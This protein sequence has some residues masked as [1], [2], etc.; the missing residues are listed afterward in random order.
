MLDTWS[1]QAVLAIAE[2]VVL[3]IFYLNKEIYMK[4][5]IQPAVNKKTKRSYMGVNVILTFDSPDSTGESQEFFD[6]L[7]PVNSRESDAI[8]FIDEKLFKWIVKKCEQLNR[9]P[10]DLIKISTCSNWDVFEEKTKQPSLI[11]LGHSCKWFFGN[12]RTDLDPWELSLIER[13]GFGTG[14]DM[15][16]VNDMRNDPAL[17]GHLQNV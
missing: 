14:V 10:N 12:G 11:A 7:I 1:K 3:D 4:A 5:N 2:A 9:E 15:S 8:T 17:N 6:L 13:Y 16:W